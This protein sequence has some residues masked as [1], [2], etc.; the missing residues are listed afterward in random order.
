MRQATA[1][2]SRGRSISLSRPVTIPA[3]D[4]TDDKSEYAMH[5]IEGRAGGGGSDDVLTLGCH[6]LTMTHLDALGHLWDASGMWGGR[7]ATRSSPSG[8]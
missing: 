3:E 6:G 7:D 1:L 4:A 2:V 5:R 8:G